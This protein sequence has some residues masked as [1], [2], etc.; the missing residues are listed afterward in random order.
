M[1]I[2][3]QRTISKETKFNGVGLHTGQS[4]ELKLIPAEPNTGIIFK[5]VD[6]LKNKIVTPNY[7]T[8]KCTHKMFNGR[9]FHTIVI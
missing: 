1:S 3:N 5:R 8:I 9:N 7:K 2:F 4:V 6:L